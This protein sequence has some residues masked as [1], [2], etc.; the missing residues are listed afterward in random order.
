MD[1][2][3]AILSEQVGDEVR[4]LTIRQFGDLAADAAT[5]RHVNGEQTGIGT[6][7]R[8]PDSKTP[9]EQEADRIKRTI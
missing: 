7:T 9:A 3:A 4:W 2:I 6:V 8:V 1:V 5:H